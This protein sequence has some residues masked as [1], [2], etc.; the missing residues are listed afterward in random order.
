MDKSNV[1]GPK[2]WYVLH[3]MAFHY[4]KHPNKVTKKKYYEMIMNF[5]LFLPHQE[6]GNKFSALL[7]KYPVTPY[8]DSRESFIKWTHFIHNRVNDGLGKP[9]LSY[10]NFM[11]MYMNPSE[12]GKSN[13]SSKSMIEWIKT[14]SNAVSVSTLLIIITLIY[15]LL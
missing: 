1:W 8:L 13:S 12:N 5:P 7:D 10:V 9:R 11:N 14:N 15:K 3:M 4:P 2:Y 6:M